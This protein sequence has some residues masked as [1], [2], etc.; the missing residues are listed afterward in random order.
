VESTIDFLKVS[1]QIKKVRKGKGA[2]LEITGFI[3]MFEN[4]T[5][6]DQFLIQEIE[7]L[8]S[9]MRM[10]FMDKKLHR[11]ALFRNVD[12]ISSFYEEQSSDRAKRNFSKWFNEFYK[13]VNDG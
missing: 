4:R 11:Y 3:N 8:Q 9:M 1:L 7:E 2:D 12:T 6:D 5:L 13:I 10:E